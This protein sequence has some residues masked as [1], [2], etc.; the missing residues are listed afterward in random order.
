MRGSAGASVRA[1]RVALDLFQRTHMQ[2]IAVLVLALGAAHAA[3]AFAGGSL[4]SLAAVRR[5]PAAPSVVRLR[6]Q[7]VSSERAAIAQRAAI[8]VTR[9]AALAVSALSLLRRPSALAADAPGNEQKRGSQRGKGLFIIE[10]DFPFATGRYPPRVLDL[11]A[12]PE[13]EGNKDVY[14]AWGKCVQVIS[15]LWTGSL[16]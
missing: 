7:G 9:R 12:L 1:D 14:N 6:A 4:S 3:E 5:Q 16:A 2:Q 11:E 15:P 13:Q 8:A 10:N